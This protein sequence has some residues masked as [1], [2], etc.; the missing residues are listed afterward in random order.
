MNQIELIYEAYEVLSDEDNTPYMVWSDDGKQCIGFDCIEFEV[1]EE[2]EDRIYYDVKNDVWGTYAYINL[3][4]YKNNLEATI[5][6]V[7]TEN[8][9]DCRINKRGDIRI[10]GKN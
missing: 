9:F 4:R 6:K 5:I 7:L 8:G 10:R 2:D 1:D 3:R